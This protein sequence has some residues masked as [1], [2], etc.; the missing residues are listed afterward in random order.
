MTKN[1]ASKV[2]WDRVFQILLVVLGAAIA[3]ISTSINQQSNEKQRRLIVANM[4][5]CC[6]QNELNLSNGLRNKLQRDQES[7][8]NGRYFIG[9]FQWMHADELLLATVKDLGML[10]RDVVKDFNIYLVHLRQCQSHRDLLIEQLKNSDFKP[11]F[12]GKEV[13]VYLVSLE[14]LS[15]SGQQLIETIDSYYP[16]L[17]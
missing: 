17:N 10:K 2:I 16:R 1:N 14:V 4:I 13:T 11:S 9:S 3:L 6:V 7:D 5:R 8:F 12:A 15:Q